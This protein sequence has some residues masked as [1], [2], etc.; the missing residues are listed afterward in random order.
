MKEYVKSAKKAHFVLLVL[1]SLCLF[2]IWDYIEYNYSSEDRTVLEDKTKELH[3]LQE[4]HV[5]LYSYFLEFKNTRNPLSYFN[6]KYKNTESYISRNYI[7][8]PYDTTRFFNSDI[9][10]ITFVDLKEY[11]SDIDKLIDID[12]AN[13]DSLN[14]NLYQLL[15][16]LQ[17]CNS[18][19]DTLETYRVS[20]PLNYRTK[21]ISQL[22]SGI[23]YGINTGSLESGDL[24]TS[25]A[26]EV[27]KRIEILK[28]QVDF[29][30]DKLSNTSNSEYIIPGIGFS[31]TPVIFPICFLILSIL[32]STY[33]E[34]ILKTIENSKGTL[35]VDD[36]CWIVF[37]KPGWIWFPRIYLWIHFVIGYFT[38]I[39]MFYFPIPL[40]K[41]TS[42]RFQ[43]LVVIFGI[44][45]F[46]LS[47][48][49]SFRQYD[50]IFN[51]RAR[52]ISNNGDPVRSPSTE[53]TL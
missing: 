21:L 49:I 10:T 18:I 8:N 3:A 23:N 25:D 39:V 14:T 47:I 27:N 17:I 34:Q 33:V 5:E 46:L 42:G 20:E 48:L 38:L 53:D 11:Y 22:F 37:T 7:M 35:I 6:N 51:I 44:I 40:F 29:L 13:F 41:L 1:T 52:I 43:T 26:F 31:I 24:V 19:T 4:I 50:F 9:I 15:A 45:Y 28:S 32:I 36:L 12:L 16:R 2:S 30:K